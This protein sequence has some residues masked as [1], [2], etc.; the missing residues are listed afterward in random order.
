MLF[1]QSYYFQIS[2]VLQFFKKDVGF[3]ENLFQSLSGQKP[4]YILP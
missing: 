1:F 2:T 4:T 3:S